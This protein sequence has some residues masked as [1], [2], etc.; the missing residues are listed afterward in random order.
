M[1]SDDWYRNN[2]WNDEIE[3]L[4]YEKLKRARS[5]RD[6]YIIIQA[7]HLSESFPLIS[8]QLI[9][10]YFEKRK[11]K[12]DDVRAYWAQ[13]I[14]FMNLGDIDK[15]M[16]A[17]RA[18]LK[19]EEEFPNHQTTAYVDYPYI[20]ATN[21]IESEYQNVLSVLTKH[22]SRLMFPLDK[23]KWHASFALINNDYEQAVLALDV[24]KVKRSGFR[25]HQD[26]G[27]VGKEHVNVIKVLC[28]IG[29]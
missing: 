6:Q 10:E 16:E 20:V 1:S 26:V 2:K 22:H 28:K 7:S 12:F 21:A 18:I 4:F 23:F 15:A 19:R 13:S 14:A 8:L 24:A 11:D 17:Y 25:F 5:Q 29:T 9:D 3:A 27:L